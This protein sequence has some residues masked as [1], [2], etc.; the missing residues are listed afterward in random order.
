LGSVV[1]G[2]SDD[3]KTVV[4]ACGSTQAAFVWRDGVLAPLGDLFDGLGASHALGVSGNGS[5]VVGSTWLG[6]HSEAFAYQDGVMRGLGDLPGGAFKSIAYAV[7]A[8]GGTIVGVGST[9]S[10]DIQAV[11]WRDDVIFELDDLPGGNT[12]SL[13]R[14]ASADGSVIVGWGYGVNGFEAAR[15]TAAG[16]T[17]LGDLPGGSFRGAKGTFYF[18][19]LRG[20][21]RGRRDDS[22][23]RWAAMRACQR[24]VPNG[25]PR[26]IL[27]FNAASSAGLCAAFT[28]ASQFRGQPYRPFGQQGRTPAAAPPGQT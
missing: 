22:M 1:D 2:V 3:G 21:P 12:S 10:V 18:S 24:G 8:D 19:A 13:A 11:A 7:S 4:G 14:G 25:A 5:M 15:W 23:P 20:R 27:R 6:T 17:G 16:V 26:A 28:V 9:P